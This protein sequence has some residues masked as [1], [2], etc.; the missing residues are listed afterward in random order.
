MIEVT[1][2]TEHLNVSNALRDLADRIDALGEGMPMVCII[3]TGPG[4]VVYALG[5]PLPTMLANAADLL[6]GVVESLPAANQRPN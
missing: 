3:G 2:A 1:D 6:A 5:G 4:A